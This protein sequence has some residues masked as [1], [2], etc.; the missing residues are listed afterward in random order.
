MV[1][2]LWLRHYWTACGSTCASEELEGES[3]EERGGAPRCLPSS[4]PTPGSLPSVPN[5]QA[6]CCCAMAA[7]TFTTHT[8]AAWR[9]CRA[10]V[11][12]ALVCSGAGRGKAPCKLEVMRQRLACFNPT[13]PVPLSDPL[14]LQPRPPRCPHAFQ[15]AL[16]G[17]PPRRSTAAASGVASC[18]A[19]PPK[20]GK[21]RSAAG[22]T[23]WAGS[24]SW[25]RCR[26]ARAAAGRPTAATR[27]GD[28]PRLRC[29][30][31]PCS[32]L[33]PSPAIPHCPLRP[34]SC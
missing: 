17:A 3:G 5:P 1:L 4:R 32:S 13:C 8:A 12:T 15:S 16:T 33:E 14:H 9:A 7:H 19:P 21:R 22:R 29:T 20:P 28:S 23:G 6:N 34:S 27:P 25:S 10:G 31:L 24:R 30:L 11:G 26:T 18:S 2:T